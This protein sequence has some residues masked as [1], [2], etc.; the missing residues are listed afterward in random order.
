MEYNV[1]AIVGMAG[2]GKSE[3]AKVLEEQGYRRI[4]F[5]DVTDE[6][7]EK[8]GLP[9]NEENERTVRELLRREHGMAAYAV[10]NLPKIDRLLE[11]GN[12]VVDGLYSWE[13]Y[14]LMKSHYGRKLL[15][16]AVWSSP[17]TRYRRLADR[18]IRPLNDRESAERDRSEIE[19]SHK[20][21][22]I[23]M[24][25]FTVVNESSL[26]ELRRQTSE[27]VKGLS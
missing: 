5:G 3:V 13:E 22:P 18:P 9:L 6:E 27:I 2:S 17:S 19:N 26:A 25:D 11:S 12:V 10:L 4:R 7:V 15:L 20:G 24:A 21:G 14:T 23:A 1:V 8:R 16:V